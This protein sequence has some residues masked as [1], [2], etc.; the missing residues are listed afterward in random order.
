MSKYATTIAFY[1]NHPRALARQISMTLSDRSFDTPFVFVVGP[2]RSGTT[3]V[4]RLLMNHSRLTGF[5][6]ETAIFSFQPVMDYQRF[7][8]FSAYPV[9][10]RALAGAGSLADFCDRLHAQCIVLPHLGRYVE[11]TPQHAK[12]MTYIAA[13]FPQAQFVFC[14]RDPRDAFCSGSVARLIPQARTIR[15]H[16]RYF[17]NCVKDVTAPDFPARSRTTVIRYEDLTSVP[18]EQVDAMSKF[19]GIPLETERQLASLATA[20]DQRTSRPEFRRLG[21][22]ITPA[23]VGRWRAEMGLADARCYQQIASAAMVHFG[24][25]LA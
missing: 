20:A 13:R 19:L 1:A 14:V 25:E 15:S 9:Y 5:D 12:W 8:S 7:R 24:Y 16:A 10:Q 18:H 11:K 3:L 17:M 2:P 21:E 22:S 23:T 4:H 6:D